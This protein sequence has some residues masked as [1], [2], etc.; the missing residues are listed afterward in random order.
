MMLAGYSPNLEV[1][2]ISTVAGNQTVLKTTQNALKIL[3]VSGLSHIRMFF[4]D[5]SKDFILF[6]VSC[7]YGPS[8]SIS[9][10]F[11]DLSGNPW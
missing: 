10:T 5:P 6:C 3:S 4:Q 8:C 2:G 1:L 7:C 11:F 9:S